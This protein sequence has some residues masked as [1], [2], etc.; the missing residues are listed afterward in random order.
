MSASF[1]RST[2]ERPSQVYV[3]IKKR[4][5]SLKDPERNLGINSYGKYN[6][7]TGLYEVTFDVSKDMEMHLN[8]EYEIAV[9]AADYRGDASLGW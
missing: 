4:A 9:H 3:S 8:G 1:L 7:D 2:S 6:K 5:H